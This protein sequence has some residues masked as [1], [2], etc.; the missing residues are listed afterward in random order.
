MRVSDH[1]D[2]SSGNLAAG[3]IPGRGLFWVL[4]QESGTFGIALLETEGLFS[5]GAKHNTNQPITQGR[6]RSS[7]TTQGSFGRLLKRA[8]ML[9]LNV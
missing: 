3:I 9:C 1:L 4:P 6:S 5:T 7:L 8:D 2:I